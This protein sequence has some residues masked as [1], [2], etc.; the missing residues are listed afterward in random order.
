MLG[1]L[2]LGHSSEEGLLD[3]IRLD[4]IIVVD[5]ERVLSQDLAAASNCKNIFS[6][7]LLSLFGLSESMPHY[8]LLG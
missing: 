4:L 6:F 8:Y 1:A 3:Q 7:Y 2:K 5:R